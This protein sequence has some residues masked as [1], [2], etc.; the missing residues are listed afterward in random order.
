ME[1]CANSI[2]TASEI[3]REI[4]GHEASAVTIPK[5]CHCN[6]IMWI[7]GQFRSRPNYKKNMERKH[8]RKKKPDLA[9]CQN[10]QTC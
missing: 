9:H 8:K 1:K 2:Q 7:V 10:F 4:V 6:G 3:R 5:P